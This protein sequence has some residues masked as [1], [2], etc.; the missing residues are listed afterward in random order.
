[1]L[2]ARI[3]ALLR[4]APAQREPILASGSLRLYPATGRC[5]R[6]KTEITLTAREFALTEFLLRRKRDLLSRATIAEHVSDDE[7]DARQA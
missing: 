7:R 6:G 4:R 3:R 2:V 1:M 5:R